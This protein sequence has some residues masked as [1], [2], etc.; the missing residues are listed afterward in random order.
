MSATSLLMQGVKAAAKE[1][2]KQAAVLIEKAEAAAFQKAMAAVDKSDAGL[3]KAFKSVD[4]DKSGKISV[5]E[6]MGFIR[7]TIKDHHGEGLDDQTVKDMIA[8]ADT[9]NDGE[10]DL[11]EFKVIMRATPTGKNDAPGKAAATPKKL[12]FGEY[13]AQSAGGAKPE[14]GGKLSAMLTMKRGTAGP[15]PSKPMQPTPS[16]ANDVKL[17]TAAAAQQRT[18]LGLASPG[19]RGV[20]SPPGGRAGS[21]SGSGRVGSPPGGRA[22]SPSGSGRA[23][24]PGGSRIGSA[25]TPAKYRV[26]PQ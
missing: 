2:E 19:A 14:A 16:F 24:S 26:E 18:E 11:D 6:M 3:E 13:M 23:G 10:V 15:S 25:R 9:N 5:G 22:G 17:L 21:P 4:E 20:V 12:T 8:A 7:R 1:R